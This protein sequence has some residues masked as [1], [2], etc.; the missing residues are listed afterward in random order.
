ASV[1]AKSCYDT[2][3]ARRLRRPSFRRDRVPRPSPSFGERMFREIQTPFGFPIYGY[4][5]MIVVGFILCLFVGSREVRRLGIPDRV[6]DLAMV[7]LVCGI[8]GGRL[9][10][11]I[12][13]YEEFANRSFLAFFQIWEGGLVFYGGALGGL[14]GGLVFLLWKRLPIPDYMDMIA[15]VAP[16]A[17]FFGRWGCFLNG[18]CF[19]RLCEPGAPWGVVFPESAPAAARHAD[20]GLIAPG[21]ASLPV[22]PVQ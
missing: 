9:F 11:Y 13:F 21:S 1:R 2:V 3:A 12:Q 8:L 17:V 10:Y 14:T 6:S 18:C 19:G 4:G 15:V 16:I 7:L 5:L 22:H 20:W